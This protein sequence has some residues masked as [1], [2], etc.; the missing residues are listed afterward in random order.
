MKYHPNYGIFRINILNIAAYLFKNGYKNETEEL[1]SYYAQQKKV[2]LKELYEL[3]LNCSGY[4]DRHLFWKLVGANQNQNLELLDMVTV[5]GLFDQYLAVLQKEYKTADALNFNLALYF[6]HRGIILS[7][8]AADQGGRYQFNPDSLF[9]KAI[10]HYQKVSEDYL[11]QSEDG[12]DEDM[13][14]QEQVK[15][16]IRRKNFFLYPDHF[17]KVLNSRDRPSRYFSDRFFLFLINGRFFDRLYRDQQDLA[18]VNF[19]I[20][21]YDR[22]NPPWFISRLAKNYTPLD[23]STLPKIDSIMTK[24]AL[25]SRL[26]LNRL[27]LMLMEKYRKQGME[28]EWE[29]IYQKLEPGRF[30]AENLKEGSVREQEMFSY[31]VGILTGYLATKGRKQEV[32]QILKCYPKPSNL[33]KAYA[34]APL[35]LVQ[36]SSGPKED[37]F[38][39]LD[40]AMTEVD[41]LKDFEFIGDDPR[42]A[43]VLSLSLAG[44]KDMDDLARKFVSKI[45]ISQ[46]NGV[47]QSW[48]QGTAMSGNYYQAY[49]SIPEILLSE[50]LHYLNLILS[51]EAMKKEMNNEWQT[52]VMAFQKYYTWQFINFEADIF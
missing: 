41:R 18:L 20:F 5:N 23:E 8:M 3:M 49:S 28:K 11:N 19:W 29:L 6:K 1:M 45:S 52:F 31:H 9:R 35:E 30:A 25:A 15:Q 39:Y 7:K 43:V 2:S 34:I 27:R 17:Q 10:A 44:G 50:R 33:I 16:K 14:F 4:L 37:A 36:G 21:E 12:Y 48:I 24:N 13:N 47:L 42:I 26:N 46:Q 40:S 22:F 32:L 38:E 51:A